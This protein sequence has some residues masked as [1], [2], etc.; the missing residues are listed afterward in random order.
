MHNNVD[1]VV[2]VI[3]VTTVLSR[4][5]KM[6]SVNIMYKRI[7]KTFICISSLICIYVPLSNLQLRSYCALLYND[8]PKDGAIHTSSPDV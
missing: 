7:N 6:Q 5:E 1:H 3:T 4:R 2:P 8:F